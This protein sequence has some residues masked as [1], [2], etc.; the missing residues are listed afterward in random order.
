MKMVNRIFLALMLLVGISASAQN[1]TTKY[2]ILISDS[3]KNGKISSNTQSTYKNQIVTVT[4][5]PDDGYGLS[6]GGLYY[7]KKNP[8]GTYSAPVEAENTSTYKEDRANT[9]SFRFRMPAADVRLTASFVR[10]GTLVIHQNPTGRSILDTESK[11]HKTGGRLVPKYGYK[12][13]PTDSVLYNL[14]GRPLILEIKPDKINNEQYELVKLDIKNADKRYWV[15]TD[16]TLTVK[17]PSANETVHVT[18]YFGKKN[19]Q[20][21]VDADTNIITCSLSNSTPKPNEEV[22]ATLLSKSD[23]IPA[24]FYVEGCSGLPWRV[25]KPERQSDGGWKVV[26]R[27]KVGYKDATVHYS[28]QRVYSV[29]VKDKK[30]SGR[31]ETLIPEMIPD[32]PGVA[33]PGQQVPILFTMPENFSASY[34]VKDAKDRNQTPIVYHNA[35]QNSFA[36]KG[37]NDWKESTDY[38]TVGCLH[39]KTGT[40]TDGNNYWRTSAKNSMSQEVD[41][42][43]IQFPAHAKSKVNNVEM[44]SIAA[45]AS[46]NPRY[47]SVAKASIESVVDTIASTW[48]FAD[49]EKKEDG[50]QTVFKTGT[51]YANASKLR[52]VV[53]GSSDDATKKKSYD[54]PQFDNLCLLLPVANRSTIKDKDVMVVTMDYENIT[55]ELSP[56]GKQNKAKAIQK[57]NAKVTLTNVTTDEQGD[58]VMFMK[59]DVIRIKGTYD[60][61]YAIY[62][63]IDAGNV[64]LETDSVNVNDNAVYYHYIVREDDKNLTFTPSVDQRKVKIDNQYGGRI[65]VDAETPEAGKKVTVTVKPN[66]G[67]TLKLLRTIPDGIVTF[68]EEKVDATTRGGTYSF[69]M[70]TS[71]ITL[72]P[73]FIVPITSANQLD[74]ISTCYGEFRLTTDLNLG[75]KWTSSN[76]DEEEDENNENN[77]NNNS[78]NNSNNHVINLHGHFDGQGHQITYGGERSLFKLV[79]R[80]ASVRHLR[81]KAKLSGEESTIGGITGYNYGTIEDCEVTGSVRNERKGYAPVG[82]VAGENMPDM[83]GGIISYCHVACNGLEG[84]PSYGIAYQKKGSTIRGNVFTGR[85][86]GEGDAYMI[87]NEAGGSTIEDNFCLIHDGNAKAAMNLGVTAVGQADLV[88]LANELEAYPVFAASIKARYDGG[89]AINFATTNLVH[90]VNQSATKAMEGTVVTGTV[91]VDGNNHLTGITVS[92]ADG[93][94]AQSCTFKDNTDNTYNFSFVMPAH[95]VRVSFT[96]AEGRFIYNVKQFV[97]IDDVQGTYYLGRDIDLYNWERQ[98][99]LNG[100]FD[101]RGHTIRYHGEGS[102]Q[103]L[104]IKIRRGSVLK[105]LR[106]VGFVETTSDCGGIVYEH[107]GNMTDC[108]FTG[109]IKKLT[110]SPTSKVQDHI[111][112]LAYIAKK[113]SSIDHCS[114]T[115][116]LICTKNQEEINSN[117]LC[118]KQR[119]NNNLKNNC[120]WVSA[121]DN[122]QSAAMRSVTDA[123]RKQYPV[124]AMGILDRITPRVVVG[125]DTMRV[126]HGK[127]LDKLT[128]VDGE[129]FSCTADIQVK[130]VVYQR[131]AT[132]DGL[133]PWVLPFSFN[134]IAAKGS[135]EYKKAQ[136]GADNRPELV[137]GSTLTLSGSGSTLSYQAYEPWAVKSDATEY[138]LT[139]TDGPITIKA[140]DKNR[141]M[142]YESVLDRGSIYVTYDSIP[143]TSCKSDV[144]YAWDGTKLDF[145]LCGEEGTPTTIQPYRFYMQFYNY[146][147]KGFVTYE[148]TNWSKTAASKRAAPRRA[149]SVVADGWQPIFLD[150]RQPQS[151]TTRMLDYYDVAYLADMHADAINPDGDKPVS[152][153]SLVYQMVNNRMELPAAIPLL[154]RARRSDAQP[155][156]DAK[157]GEE[158]DALIMLSLLTDDEEDEEDSE[159]FE[160]LDMPHYWCNSFGKRVDVWPL[161]TPEQYAD[162]ADTGC[163]LFKDSDYDQSFFYANSTDSRTTPP[164]SYCITAIDTDSYEFLPLLDDRVTVEFIGLE[165][166]ATGISSLTAKPAGK[167]E[168]DGPAYNLNGQRVDASY[169]GIILKNGRK[170][171]KR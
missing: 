88:R 86:A 138:V 110:A 35:L 72:I 157:T 102:C 142:H 57:A 150:P 126:E 169:K 154:V 39:I 52:F 156:T 113:S 41:L 89:Y 167:S 25:G 158:I 74:S 151:V 49:L 147:R 21:T 165:E 121:T 123:I 28:N 146:N 106:V 164:M 82:G 5:T 81:V 105:G 99:T 26:Y 36:D 129:P 84:K 44:L 55:I 112:A 51:V 60:N 24:D 149:A 130:Q 29:T 34:T 38:A 87:C 32:Y 23:Y 118:S 143:A 2:S 135:F 47:G 168:A 120:Y 20:V 58:S 162:F 132:T 131:K 11:T 83:D 98:I 14:S 63:M 73:E 62:E 80:H 90:K 159:E 160:V 93:S 56:E 140:T 115:G 155:L 128:L 71:Y 45:I 125:R 100:H 1:D 64:A 119:D 13:G 9:Q 85:F 124:Y 104:F 15:R 31:V 122:A 68:A 75:D 127:T 7:A 97:A 48:D 65:E 148:Q 153:V 27:F 114:A 134:R 66:A 163:M 109:R 144:L 17:I 6:M 22:T 166:E 46:I 139:S 67:S 59:D 33:L 19:Y 94:N 161:P 8:N 69:T 101:G 12:G 54:G 133:E 108:H 77:E 152:V 30:K 4:C 107:Q 96:T 145:F 103:G 18:P 111:A 61:G 170:Y 117:P 136:Q 40:D 78:N 70:P 171:I 10:T 79:Q 116:E 50:W 37:M 95:E 137:D 16:S 42:S 3:I 43:G 141:I 92:A 91:S 76:D 53:R